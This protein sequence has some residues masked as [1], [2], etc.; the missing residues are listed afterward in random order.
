MA[1]MI[2]P[3]CAGEVPPG[4]KFCGNCGQKLVGAGAPAETAGTRMSPSPAPGPGGERRE[5]TVLFADVS[6]FTAMCERLDPE[7]VQAVMNECFAGLGGAIQDEEG[8]IDKYI[9][10]NVMALFGAPVAH[11]DD[12]AR[13]CRAALAMQAF[14]RGFAI[15]CRELTGVELRM[16]IGVHCGLVLAGDVGS[17]VRMD[18]SVMGD[19][20]NLASRLESAAAPGAILV[21]AEV[22][23]R[24]RGQF[25]LGPVRRLS[26][27]GKERPVE[28]HELVREISARGR[29]ERSAPLVGRD[30]ELD[31]LVARWREA[32]RG[33]GWV[34]V[35][36]EIGIGK[37]R[38]VDE[39][40]RRI[41][42]SRLLAVAGTPNAS[43]RPFGLV[44]RLVLAAVSEVTG[45]APQPETREAF[46][47]AVLPL[48]EALT[49]FLDALWYL[50]TPTRVI[51]PAPDPD[52]QTLRR[53]LER[54]VVTLLGGLAAHVPRLTLFVD[55]YEWADDASAALLE[56]LAEGPE[57]FPVPVVV[58]TREEGRPPRRPEA[59]I[60][61]G[62]LPDD[63][64]NE[65]LDRL[66]HGV[67]LPVELRRDILERAAGV[68][69]FLEEMVQALVE[70][71]L[72]A[73]GTDGQ[74]CWACRAE[75]AAVSLPASIRAAM[76]ARLDRVERA[77]RELVNQCSVQG[78]EFDL[79]VAEAVR[80]APARQGPPVA[81]LL[82]ALERLALVAGVGRDQPNRWAF[83]QP[84]LQEACYETLL[85]R[86]RRALHAETAE[87]LCE[88]LGGPGYV[89]PALLAHHYERA[90]RWREAA[91]AH[92]RAGRQAAELFLNEDAV[93]R[94]RRALETIDRVA[95]RWEADERR[96]A[97]AHRGLARV[98]LRVGAYAGAEEHAI[99]M[100]EVAARPAD[101]AE[102]DRLHAAACVHTGRTEEAEALLVAAVA[103]AGEDPGEVL[104]RVLYDLAELHHRAN[105][106]AD[107]LARL[108]E[109][110][111]AMAAGDRLH[112]IRA[113][114]LEG[115][116]A[117]TEG[118][119][120]DAAALYARAYD[121]A[122]RV[123]SLSDRARAANNLGN[124]ARDLGDYEASRRQ[125]ARALEIWERTGDTEC[126]AGAHNN[127]GNLAMSQGDF[128]SARVHHEWSLQACRKIGNVHGAALAQANL[129][130]LAIEQEDGPRGVA[131]AQAALETLGASGNAVLRGLVLIVLGEAH[132]AAG[133]VRAAQAA[134][135][136][137]LREYDEAHHPLAVAGAARGVGRLA[138]ARGRP[139]DALPWLDRAVAT[140]ER[141]K[142]AQE[143]AR[144]TLYRAEALWRLG[145]RPRACADLE[146]ALARFVAM[147]ADRDVARVE[148]LIRELAI[149]DP[150]GS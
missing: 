139:A 141:L 18:Y 80:R 52:A 26:V 63:A 73:Q 71:G 7:D 59:T 146:G 30:R 8:Y 62:R 128:E 15:R 22:A 84:L 93:R 70:Q 24:T 136:Q 58:A 127:L 104:V 45:Q 78:V 32:C 57:G 150:T 56:S 97:L 4:F 47:A 36:G 25:E 124:A 81:T 41:E 54:G 106:T 118:R 77:P 10:D 20:V 65:L 137:V 76:V 67:P 121:E 100:R 107:A 46:A 60:R 102:A 112:L 64:S 74:W 35:R 133:E 132:L 37:T 119:F 91:D 5:V 49:P 83:R 143:A 140:Y 43:R 105:R 82:P 66:L 149:A 6:G 86:E 39:A 113:D 110:R 31:V 114:M 130:T 33:R 115:K 123:G 68:P 9:G 108:A 2:C 126:I 145:E 135:D 23:K 125:F 50:A 142:R 88:L 53:T 14:L 134:F 3:A 122:E 85:I 129:A 87:A 90:E 1:G 11:E 79:D 99:A 19:T 44:R 72:L 120:A 55:S 147:R 95:T 40:G 89:S 42:E 111:R 131:S 61:L 51:V 38:L 148:R 69:L 28:A 16:R 75:A 103:A 29:D 48:G 12:P 13:A 138:L 17:G 116:I 21:S 92:L 109:S 117:H 144:T 34:E 98:Y 101:R 27:K 96:V 94:Y